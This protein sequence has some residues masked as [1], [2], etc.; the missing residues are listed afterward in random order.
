LHTSE[1]DDGVAGE[2]EAL[3]EELPHALDV[4]DG[5]P[6]LAAAPAHAGVRD[7][8]QDGALLAAGARE[9]AHGRRRPRHRRRQRDP[10]GQGP[11]D[12]R[13]AAALRALD[14]ALAGAHGEARAAVLAPDR[15]RRRRRGPAAHVHGDPS[16]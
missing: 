8:D 16:Y 1:H 6:Q 2:G 10:R 4:V 13:D 3:A 14:G 5:S 15:R 11:P 12:A 7:A 9:G